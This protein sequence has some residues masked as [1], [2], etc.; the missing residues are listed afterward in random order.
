MKQ[1]PFIQLIIVLFALKPKAKVKSRKEKDRA[2]AQLP[3]C[4]TEIL[5]ESCHSHSHF[6]IYFRPHR[7][8]PE[9]EESKRYANMISI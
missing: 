2:L 9:S 3:N 6:R 5:S 7:N 8:T 4:I 1:G